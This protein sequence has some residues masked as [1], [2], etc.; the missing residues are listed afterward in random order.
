M[1]I[2]LC[3]I[4]SLSGFSSILDDQ[5]D[6][7]VG[8]FKY[9]AIKPLRNNNDLKYRLGKKLFFDNRLSLKNS[10][11]CSTC[12]DP[13]F[14]STDALPFSIGLGAH[15]I[16]TNRVQDIAR[17]TRRSS[18]SLFNKG[19]EDFDKMFWDGRVYYMK[20]GNRYYTPEPGLN[21]HDPK[22][23]HITEVLGSA[24]AAQALFPMLSAI[25]MKG[26]SN[27]SNIEVWET[28]TARI[29]KTD[30][31]RA[32]FKAVYNKNVDQLNVGHIGNALAYFQSRFFQATNTN[33]DKYLRG[34]K[35][36]MSDSE[37]RGAIVFSNK[38][39]CSRCHHG[40]FLTNFAFQNVGVPQI[41]SLE[42]KSLDLGRFEISKQE[43]AKF[44]FATQPLRNIAKTAPYF[45]N[46][47]YQTLEE[48]V[49]HYLDAKDALYFY[50]INNLNSYFSRN[51]NKLFELNND[52]STINL[53]GKNLHPLLRSKFSLTE[54]E[55]SD[56]I[57]FL[58][59]SLTEK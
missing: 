35:S 28:I 33:W 12:H 49:D 40:K 39:R 36:A 47:S 44:S 20:A 56:L 51:Y 27:L 1:Q 4:F 58:K 53:I 45:H 23:G 14:N 21:G 24:M 37:K 46:G 2:I 57:L 3:L 19:H 32:L 59:E 55:K 16:G 42:H 8:I 38:G 25:E 13:E 18:P 7:Y 54:Q 26:E 10:I 17:I 34:N 48:V 11:S 15:G 9:E 29:L 31:Y 22:F 52:Q 5:L 50:K 41:R 6:E 43:Y 30:N